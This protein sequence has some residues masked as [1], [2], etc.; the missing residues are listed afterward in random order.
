MLSKTSLSLIHCLESTHVFSVFGITVTVHEIRN[1]VTIVCTFCHPTGG[2]QGDHCGPWPTVE[3]VLH[4]L[5]K[6]GGYNLD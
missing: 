6:Q 2:K 3:V 5:F 1:S 4:W